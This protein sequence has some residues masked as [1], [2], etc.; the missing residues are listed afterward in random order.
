MIDINV[1]IGEIYRCRNKNI[2]R[3]MDE[4]DNNTPGAWKFTV[5]I[6]LNNIG[7]K[8]KYGDVYDV[9]AKGNFWEFTED[10]DEDD[11]VEL[12]SIEEYPEYFL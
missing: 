11:L 8:D 2:V 12:I 4:Y 1:R 9:T 7:N 10:Y 6:I 5:T 3:I